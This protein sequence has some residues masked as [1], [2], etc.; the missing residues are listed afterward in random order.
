M[1]EK[2]TALITGSPERVAA[3]SAALSARDYEVVPVEQTDALEEVCA[4]LGRDAIDCY[5]QLPVNVTSSGGTVVSRLHDFLAGGLLARFQAVEVVLGTLRPN[6][7]V[8]LVAGNLPA[9]FTAPDDRQARISL[10]RVLAEAV[11]TAV[12]PTPVRIAVVEH[13][14]SPE[15]IAAIAVDPALGHPKAIEDAAD[16]YPEMSYVDWRLEVLS[17]ATVES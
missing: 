15:E 9:E 11:R 13:L 10:L 3:V 8:I 14:R 1:A 5:V 4:A 16:R 17:L 12:A 2:P 6:A 7:A